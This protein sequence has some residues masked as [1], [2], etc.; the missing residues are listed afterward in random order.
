MGTVAL[1]SAA[2]RAGFIDRLK[3]QLE[4]LVANNIYLGQ[5]LIEAALR[6]VGE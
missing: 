5:G 2:K 3:P 6:D 1:L 4:A